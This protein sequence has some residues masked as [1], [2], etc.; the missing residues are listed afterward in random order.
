ME[1]NTKLRSYCGGYVLKIKYT[2]NFGDID[3]VSPVGR[4]GRI[5]QGL[6][7]ETVKL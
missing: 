1:Y 4:A 7:S 3:S 5:A 2:G 6:F